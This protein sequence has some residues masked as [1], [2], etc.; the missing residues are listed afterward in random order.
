[1]LTVVKL[2]ATALLV[3]VGLSF[4]LGVASLWR[5]LVDIAMARDWYSP[6][7]MYMIAGIAT[8]IACLPWVAIV[9][10]WLNRFRKVF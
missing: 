2:I 6:G 4:G 9:A 7:P 5:L 3:I 8:V 1:M 10:L